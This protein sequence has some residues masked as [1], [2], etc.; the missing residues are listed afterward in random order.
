M[1]YC[2]HCG[3]LTSGEPVFCNFC[4]RSY[5]VKLCPRLH[6]NPR[7]ATVCSRCG[8]RELSTPQPK[9]S[10]WWKIL[11]LVLQLLGGIALVYLSLSVVV[12]LLKSPMV[13]AGLIGL[14]FLVAAL[15]ALWI[16]LPEWLR[17]LITRRIARKERNDER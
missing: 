7:V 11:I 2:Y 15:W 1:K 10:F 4:G 16:L 5:D 8:S 14:V 12:E 17:K 3:R 9:V 6:P 13:Q